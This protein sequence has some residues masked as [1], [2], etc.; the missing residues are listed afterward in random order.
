MQMGSTLDIFRKE[1]FN[2]NWLINWLIYEFQN[3][4]SSEDMF[5]EDEGEIL[6]DLGKQL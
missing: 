1:N 4:M 2:F 6:K 3:K 5:R